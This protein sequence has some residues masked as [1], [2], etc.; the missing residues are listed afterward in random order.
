MI[1]KALQ[2]WITIAAL[3]LCF[4][5]AQAGLRVIPPSDLPCVFAGSNRPVP[6]TWENDGSTLATAEISMRLMQTSSA[7]T[8][9]IG[10]WPWKHLELQPGQTILEHAV[11][12]F[13]EVTAETCFLI[14]WMEG[15]NRI[16]G[17]TEVRVCPTNLLSEL[18]TLAGEKEGPGL[19]DP[20]SI[21]KPLLKS[22]GVDFVDLEN[23][24]IQN[25]HGR[26]VIAG[27]FTDK[28]QMHAL[29]E[30]IETIARKGSAVV[31]LQP[32]PEPRDMFKP[33]FYTVLVG[34][35]AVV[36]AQTSLV[37]S[38]ATNPQA[39]LNLLQLCRVALNPEPLRLP[40]FTAQP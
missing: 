29:H 13:P 25:S 22:T 15:T 10:Q 33:S 3:G 20:S 40:Q 32:P 39:Q 36:V 16:F 8:T 11:L 18:R 19:L 38:L 14:R 2:K 24:G 5:A 23:G 26:L 30:R 27:P 7:T 21:L 35:N 4:E 31:W 34:T 12:D 9:T 28:V 17:T 1:M 37:A 6:V